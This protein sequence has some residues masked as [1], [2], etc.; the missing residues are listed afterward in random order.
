MEEVLYRLTG[1][2][3]GIYSIAFSH[4]S[5]LLACACGYDGEIQLWNMAIG[6]RVETLHY[7]S[8]I[9]SVTFS[10]DSNLL[11]SASSNEIVKI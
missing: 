6:E 2:P 8:K 4:D 11:A 5:R 9:Y 3:G 1:Y 10:H 7:N